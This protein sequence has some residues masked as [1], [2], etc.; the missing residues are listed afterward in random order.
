MQSDAEREL[1]AH[2]MN[3]ERRDAIEPLGR[4]DDAPLS[5]AQQRL[6]F[7]SQLDPDST[8]YVNCVAL[9][10]SGPLDLG[11]LKSALTALVARH[12]V[13]RTRFVDAGGGEPRQVISPEA[14]PHWAVIDVSA[15]GDPAGWE[16]RAL[17]TVRREAALPMDLADG[18]LLRTTVVRL[19]DD[20]HI[21]L[22]RAHHIVADGWSFGVL[23]RELRELYGSHREGRAPRLPELPVQYVDFAVWQRDRLRGPALDRQAAY[24][25]ERLRGAEPVELPAD[26]PRPAIRSGHGAS[27]TV[28]I[29]ADVSGRL[30]AA[31]ERHGIT[32]F[33]GFLSVFGIL[34]ANHSGRT[35]VLVG[36][37]VAGRHRAEIEDL[38]GFFVNTLVMRTDLS[39]DPTIAQLWERTRDDAL[40]AFAQQ[41]L[42]FDRL[43]EHLAPERDLSRTPLFQHMFVLQNGAGQDWDLP[44]VRT[45]SVPLAEQASKFDLSL[46]VEPRDGVFDARFEYATDLFDES[47]VRR[48]AGHLLTLVTAVADDQDRRVSRL[49]MLTAPEERQLVEE[50]NDTARPYPSAMCVHEII[51]RRAEQHPDRVAVTFGRTRV[52]YRELEERSN[53]VA[54]RLIE[55]GVA[56]G[57]MIG[58][59]VDRGPE[60]VV[61]V[62]G[63][64][65]AGGAYVP[66]DPD[67]PRDRLRLL[68]TDTAAPV[69]L[70][71]RALAE[72]IP[73]APERRVL[74]LDDHDWD[75]YPT[76]N[77]GPRATPDNLAYVIYTS[78]STGTPKGV[79]IRHQSLV[80]YLTGADHDFPANGGEKALLHSSITFDLTVTPLFLTLMRGHEVVVSPP[81]DQEHVE[82][83]AR[84]V[85]DGSRFA[86]LKATPSHL[87]LLLSVAGPGATINVGTVV[88]GGEPLSTRLATA[89]LAACSD[90]TVII[91]EYGHTETT[92]ACVIQPATRDTVLTDA[93]LPVGR[94]MANTRMY[95]LDAAGRL[96]PAGVV[97]ELY[98]GGDGVARGYLNRPELNAARFAERMIGGEL[99]R[100]Y[101]S[102]DLVRWRADGVMEFRGRTDDQ[103][104][105]RG[106]RIELGEIEAALCACP[107]VTEAV[108]MARADTPGAQRL[109]AYVVPAADPAGG[110]D[111]PEVRSLLRERLPEYMVPSVFVT[112][113]A[114]P[115]TR[116]GK[117]D[118][119]ALPAPD[120]SRPELA[121]AYVAPQGPAESA[122]AAVW[123]QILGVDRVGAN[124]DFFELGGHSLLATKVV[125]RLR[126]ELGVELEIRAVFTAPTVAR[127]AALLAS[128]AA[129]TRQVPAITAVD[130]G[131]PLPLSFAQQ[132]LWFLDQ[133]E[134]GSSQY[135]I[136]VTLNLRGDMDQAG[137]AH[138]LRALIARHESLRTTFDQ[139]DDTPVQIVHDTVPFTLDVLDLPED[140][141]QITAG[142]LTPMDLRRGPLFRAVLYRRSDQEHLLVMTLHHI[143]ADGWSFGVFSRELKELYDA[144]QQDRQARLPALAVQYADF[145]VWQRD[146]LRG[147]VLDEQ[148]T[149]WARQLDGLEPVELPTDRPRPAIRTGRGASLAFKVPTDVSDRLRTVFQ[150]HGITPFMGFLS[151]F[152]ILLANYSGQTDLAVGTPVAGR[153]RTEIED[154]VGVFINTLV[155]RTDLGDDPTVAHLWER[156]RDQALEAYAHQD[157]PF[158]RLVEHLHPERDLSRTPLFQHL[159][160]LQNAMSNDWEL[161]GLRIDTQTLDS[162]IAK[163][164]L[165][166]E[167]EECG[168]D[169]E[170]AFIYSTDLF[171]ESTI[172]RMAGHLL[173][174]LEAAATNPDTPITHLPMLTEPETHQLLTDW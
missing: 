166:L 32:P 106:F 174:L 100:V 1:F 89:V 22:M 116:N 51:A 70:T 159:F 112:I 19:G 115:L 130:R 62:L 46:F 117:V 104:K 15:A 148:L 164:D 36:T 173:T 17:E 125:S 71:Q 44:G 79:Q 109:V 65:K 94:P 121:D 111:V 83:A 105:F 143:I 50:W 137:L 96:V 124:D 48:M 120:G 14:E 88:I 45:G 119:R 35:D 132:R 103:V 9:S 38:V 54:H 126:A 86:L 49:P 18:R 82:L 91:N 97:G 5:Y 77:P 134:P 141:R 133:L 110:V 34:L 145:A 30:R 43:V 163:F 152:D 61:G 13:L 95:V 80:N 101:R 127:L 138:A 157:L 114:V 7:L 67:Y 63:I 75:A 139:I 2:I 93:E 81:W 33:M 169:F 118:K 135:L 107:H 74:H 160:V 162:V 156:T 146:W 42:P 37:P 108:V 73:A 27:V 29:P 41:D 56:A 85:F 11:A 161:P 142:A 92:V 158:E 31:F 23:S 20:E 136:P 168:S 123:S 6:W 165:T 147:D 4:L 53:Q 72:R 90:G 102:G 16:R 84:S 87:E 8:E 47:T 113:D 60:M 40:D 170:A 122:V 129:D 171:D 128:A 149:Y 24:W 69:V 64:L 52:T 155:M 131:A 68:L 28:Q 66:L 98:T 57:S 26:R 25:T 140:S 76:T 99:R 153:N 167:M 172:E 151:V 144:H 10:L 58:I 3:L 59:C 154:L 12:A 21:L 78:G 39:G 55:I 150:R